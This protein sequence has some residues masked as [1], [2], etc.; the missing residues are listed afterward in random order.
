MPD[1]LPIEYAKGQ[2]QALDRLWLAHLRNGADPGDGLALLTAPGFFDGIRSFN[3]HA[4]FDAHEQFEAAWRASTYPARLLPYALSKLG[5]ACH[6]SARRPLTA[7]KLAR[8]TLAIL[9][10]LPRT[11]ATIDLATFRVDLARWID[12]PAV[13]DL[14]LPYAG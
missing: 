11:Y 9:D 3:T 4:Y 13:V 5:A 14:R 1:Q 6:H 2:R 10:C 8:D 7:A 12:S